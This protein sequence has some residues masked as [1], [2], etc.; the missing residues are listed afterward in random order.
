MNKKGMELAINYL[1]GIILGI[2]LLS[3]GLIFAASIFKASGE[4][5]KMGL[6]DYF[7]VER[8]NCVQR[9][10]RVC[11]PKTKGDAETLK[12][13][14]FGVV[15]NNIYGQTKEFKLHVTFRRGLTLDDQ[16][17][18]SV[19]LKDWT[20]TDFATIELENNDDT[21]IEV[22]IRPPRGIKSGTYTF[23]VNVC[24]NANDNTDDKCD[25]GHP[26]LYAP[27]QQ[28]SVTVK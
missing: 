8:E 1:V 7:E 23:N 2:I 3:L 18:N 21:V 26:S 5:T 19:T 24:L 15:I 20:F 27:T 10:D 4:I 14:S 9:G 16:T 28:I 22:P 17:I 11:I 13:T 25:S 12:T 6:P